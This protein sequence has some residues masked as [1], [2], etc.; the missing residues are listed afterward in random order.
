VSD[1][2][3]GTTET[4]YLSSYGVNGLGTGVGIA[5]LDMTTLQITPLGM[6]AMPGTAA[7]TGTGDARLFGVFTYAPAPPATP[8]LAQIDKTD[9]NVIAPHAVMLDGMPE[10]FGA[11]AF[12]GGDFFLFA[13]TTA[14]KYAPATDT[15]TVVVPTLAS[16]LIVGA[17]VSTCAPFTTT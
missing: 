16:S 1:T 2:P 17:A 15:T 13:N 6:Y 5:K 7:L 8:V 11:I 4:L 10:L 3:G 12:W 14:Y 9:S